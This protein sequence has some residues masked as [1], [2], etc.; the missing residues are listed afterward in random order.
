MADIFDQIDSKSSGDIFDQISSTPRTPADSSDAMAD[1]KYGV[2]HP[3]IRAA[4]NIG[5]QLVMNPIVQGANAVAPA[6]RGIEKGIGAPEGGKDLIGPDMSEAPVTSKILGDIAGGATQGLAATAAGDG[7]PFMGYAALSGLGAS[8]NN[9]PVLPAMINGVKDALIPAAAGKMGSSLASVASKSLGGLFSRFAPNIG[10]AAGMGAASVAQAQA[11]GQDPVRAAATGATFGALSPMNPLGAKTP[12]T[13]AN[14]EAMVENEG[15]PIYRNILNPGKG[16][17]KKV[18]IKSG[19]NINDSMKLAAKEALPI[20]SNEGK[21][22]NVAAIEKLKSSTAPM[23]DAQNQILASNPDKQFNLNDI[24]SQVK[25]GL[26]S[27]TKNAAELSTNKAKVDNEIN[28]EILRHG[29]NVD[30]QTLNM[31]KQGM[32]GKS[33]NPLEPN[34]NDSA[35]AIGFAAKDAIEKAYPNDT[36]KENN[37]KIG[38]YLQLQKILEATHGQ[39]VQGG[40]IGKYAARGTGTIIGGLVSAHAPFLGEVAGPLAGN[41]IGSKVNEF[42]NDPSR[43]TK[44]WANKLNNINIVDA[45][46]MAS[47]RPGVVNP[48]V[49]NAP[50]QSSMNPS[51]SALPPSETTYGKGFTM[52]TP[53]PETPESEQTFPQGSMNPLKNVQQG[54]EAVKNKLMSEKG[55]LGSNESPDADKMKDYINEIETEAR[56]QRA[57]GNSTD[58]DELDAKA[59]LERR[60]L[61]DIQKPSASKMSGLGM[62]PG[63]IAAG[64][65]GIG[66]VFNPI[67]AQAETIKDS[68][69]L[70]LP[71]NQYTMKNEGW[72]GMPYMDI[73][74]YKTVGY[75]FKEGGMAWKYVPDAVKQGRR[76]MTKEEGMFAFN[77]AYPSAVSSAQKFAGDSWDNLSDNQ[78]KALSD[79]SYQMGSLNG[80]SKLRAAVQSGNYN[81]ASREILNSKYA[82]KDAP[83]RAKQNAILMQQ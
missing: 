10:T 75:G 64:A 28:A 29:E 14:H 41:E 62:M 59:E 70:N 78:Q 19:G 15:A 36:I 39:V 48:E 17:I 27:S 55:Q 34:A 13:S 67:N 42:I 56:N 63:I 30:G 44:N 83:N 5:N 23:Y 51:M 71:S 43:I 11:T 73:N 22:D 58:A 32:W 54:I 4:Q 52:I 82:K 18:E 16:I 50:S 80:F 33:Y 24:G 21:L 20:N 53:K 6:L 81:T 38:Q 49:M 26:S 2:E 61:Q 46:A 8:G 40:K 7:N 9:K 72:K 74:G 60:K 37:T 66:S 57:K 69:A 68:H 12:M 45:P 25:F 3:Y 76:A 65:L 47:K 35:R 77:K 1:A 79:M 31:I